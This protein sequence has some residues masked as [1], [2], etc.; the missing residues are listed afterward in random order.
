MWH[1]GT[2]GVGR[3]RV[4]LLL[5]EDLGLGDAPVRLAS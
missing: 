4:L 3:L 2:S 1:I 5:H